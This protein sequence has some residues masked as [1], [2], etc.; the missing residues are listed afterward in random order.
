MS[1]QPSSWQQSRIQTTAAADGIT[2]SML[3]NFK[4][5]KPGWIWL[6]F[7]WKSQGC[8]LDWEAGENISVGDQANIPCQENMGWRINLP[9]VVHYSRVFGGEKKVEIFTAFHTFFE[10]THVQ[11]YIPSH[12]ICRRDQI[13]KQQLVSLPTLKSN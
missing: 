6:I 9:G 1:L 3:A 8:K 13:D 12:C 4:K 11:C 5:A 7:G 2:Q 10:N